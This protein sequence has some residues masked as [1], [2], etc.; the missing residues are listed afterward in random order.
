MPEKPAQVNKW[1][2][3]VKII[4]LSVVWIALIVVSF[5]TYYTIPALI[6][7]SWWIIAWIIKI[8]KKDKH[9][10]SAYDEES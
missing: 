8:L 3:I 10:G 2:E 9:D 1:K 5:Y 6:F 7:I 4:I